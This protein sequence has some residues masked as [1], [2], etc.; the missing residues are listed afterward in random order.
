M[1]SNN[2]L[3]LPPILDQSERPLLAVSGLSFHRFLG[4]S[5]DRFT[6]KAAVE[7]TEF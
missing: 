5:N 4:R 3:H 7:V 6:P 2:A 1:L